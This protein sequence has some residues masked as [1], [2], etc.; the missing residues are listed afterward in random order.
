MIG[1]LRHRI[2]FKS[3]TATPDEGGGQSIAWVDGASVWARIVAQ[4]GPEIV[5]AGEIVP[6]AQYRVTIR[7][8]T[9]ITPTMRI[10]FGAKTLEIDAVYD[11]DG[12]GRVLTVD[13]HD[14]STP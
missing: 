12:D 1:Q 2:T 4:G 3:P 14:G 9:D 8:R 10:T 7:H 6:R 13:C 11:A 5:R